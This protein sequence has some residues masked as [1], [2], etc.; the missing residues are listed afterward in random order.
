MVGVFLAVACQ[1]VAPEV[2]TDPPPAMVGINFTP[3]GPGQR[4]GDPVPL[5]QIRER[6]DVVAP[7]VDWVRTFGSQDEMGKIAEFARER[8]LKTAVG[9][10]IMDDVEH[11]E[12][13]IAALIDLGQRGLVDLAIV[14]SET[15]YRGDVTE[16]EL[17]VYLRRVRQAVPG[18]PVATADIYKTF[19]DSGPIARESDV[20]LYNS[21]PYWEGIGI[22][23]A[24]AHFHER[25]RRMVD[26][27]KGKPVWVS[28]T[29][30]PTAGQPVGDAVPTLEHQVRYFH[31]FRDWAAVHDV[32]YFWFASFDEGWKAGTG[33]GEQGAHWGLWDQQARPKADYFARRPAPDAAYYRGEQ[34][35]GGE[36]TPRLEITELPPRGQLGSIG[37]RAHH[38]RP[39]DVTVAMFVHD[40][41]WWTKPLFDEP[42]TPVWFDGRFRESAVRAGDEDADRVALFVLPR[43]YTPP[44]IGGWAELPAEIG[45][46]ALAEL[47]VARPE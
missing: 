31:E 32:P 11:N 23:H 28:E 44:L 47:V 36:G 24:V 21:Y 5:D 45:E 10:W 26:V 27:A 33:E 17:V 2:P 16:A 42:L 34:P 18:V 6:L 7:T 4:P 43:T 13:E 25:H 30:W 39:C 14:G 37:G 46:H 19:L 20:I 12:R 40:D 8:G 35:L 22:D 9:A 1:R 29:G 38:V 41:G 15:Q 3:F